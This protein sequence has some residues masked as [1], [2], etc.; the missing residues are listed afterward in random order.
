[1]P[2]SSSAPTGAL[3]RLRTYLGRAIRDIS[4]KIEGNSGLETAFAKLLP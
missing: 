1:M 2:S 4:R 3:K